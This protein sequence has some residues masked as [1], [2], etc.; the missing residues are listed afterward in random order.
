MLD[1]MFCTRTAVA[2]I[3]GSIP[4]SSVSRNS[5]GLTG[6]RIL[7]AWDEWG[8]HWANAETI[9]D[10]FVNCSV[11]DSDRIFHE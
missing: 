10:T 2:V 9:K 3:P 11:D 1:L 7:G 4:T 5:W 6:L 8:H